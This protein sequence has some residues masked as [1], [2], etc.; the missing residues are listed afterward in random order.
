[1]PR[2]IAF[3]TVSIVAAVLI[4]ACS[5]QQVTQAGA[6]GLSKSQV[7]FISTTKPSAGRLITTLDTIT[8]SEGKE[9]ASFRRFSANI[10]NS[11]TVLPGSYRVRLFCLG[12]NA[13]AYPAALFDL[14]GGYSYKFDCHL[15]GT[16]VYVNKTESVTE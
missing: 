3:K 13:S 10:N 11:V 8:D 14:R 9:V 2:T 7:A 16:R 4:S 5:I 15:E 12:H 6:S 1:M